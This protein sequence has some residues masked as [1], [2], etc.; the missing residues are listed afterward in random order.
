MWESLPFFSFIEHNLTELFEK[1]GNLWQIYQQKISTFYSSGDV[2]L[3]NDV[4]GA[5]K[6]LE[7]N[8][9]DISS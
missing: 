6:L 5:K 8:N 2:C 4:L 9:K 3:E 1:T 7:L